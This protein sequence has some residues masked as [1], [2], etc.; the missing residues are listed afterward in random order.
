M[1]FAFDGGPDGRKVID[2]FL[3]QAKNYL[4][5][6]G[7]VQLIQSSLSNIDKTLEKLDKSGFISE[8]VASEK[9]FFEEIVLINGYLI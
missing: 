7:K 6:E 9:F 8:I 2:Q 5:N 4:N 3:N 1:N